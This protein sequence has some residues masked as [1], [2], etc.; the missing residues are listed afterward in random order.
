MSSNFIEVYEYLLSTVRFGQFPDNCKNFVY[1]LIKPIFCFHFG[2]TKFSSRASGYPQFMRDIPH[3][4]ARKIAEAPLF[5]YVRV[6]LQRYQDETALSTREKSE[7]DYN[8]FNLPFPARQSEDTIICRA[9]C[10]ISS[11]SFHQSLTR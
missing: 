1:P 10:L 7:G 2:T 11:G 8:F 5:T 9:L 3:E 4:F 6:M